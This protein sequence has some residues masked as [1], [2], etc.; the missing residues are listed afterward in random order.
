MYALIRPF[1]EGAPECRAGMGRLGLEGEWFVFTS[2]IGTPLDERRVRWN[3]RGLLR[4]QASNVFHDLRHA[5]F[6]LLAA[7]GMSPKVISEMVGH[8]DIGLTQNVYQHMFHPV[9]RA[10]AMRM[11]GLLIRVATRVALGR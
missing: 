6:F 10:A 2:R 5:A 3:F 11:N 4:P 8:S 9:R 7:Q 1:A